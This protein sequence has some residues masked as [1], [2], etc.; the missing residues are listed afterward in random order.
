MAIHQSHSIVVAGTPIAS[1]DLAMIML[2]GRGATAESI[3]ALANELKANRVAYLAPQAAGNSWYP[4]R[5]IAPIASNQPWLDSALETL[6]QLFVQV[7]KAG[8]P[9]ERTIILGF[10]QGACLSLEFAARN[11]RRYGAVIALSGALIEQGDQ[12]REY[13]GSLLGT[14]VFLGCSDVDFHIPK[15]RV[16]RSANLLK[17]IEADVDMRIYPGMEHTVNQDEIEVVNKL[18]EELQFAYDSEK[19]NC[20]M[21]K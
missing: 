12:A 11:P 3:L 8:I 18:I 2:H 7:S 20:L 9:T 19:A 13:D 1:A 10:S 5:F 17:Q 14:P 16:E 6:S 15:A 21:T 4:N